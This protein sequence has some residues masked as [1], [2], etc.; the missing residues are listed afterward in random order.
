MVKQGT[1]PDLRV[2]SWMT[3]RR[4]WI[5][6]FGDELLLGRAA[7]LGRSIIGADTDTHFYRVDRVFPSGVPAPKGE[8]DA[9]DRQAGDCTEFH[10][11][12]ELSREDIVGDLYRSRGRGCLPKPAFWAYPSGATGDGYRVAY[13]MR[14]GTSGVDALC[15]KDRLPH[16]GRAVLFLAIQSYRMKVL[17]AGLEGGRF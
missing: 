10:L 13:A 1:A 4:A 7:L 8:G 12:F 3:R 16:P 14:A 2:P 11:G 9:M 17:R 5:F 6:G 15:L